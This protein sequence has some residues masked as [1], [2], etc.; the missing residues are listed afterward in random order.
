MAKAKIGTDEFHDRRKRVTDLV[1][2]G[3]S[4]LER[5][6]ENSTRYKAQLNS[7]TDEEFDDWASKFEPDEFKH[8]IQ[9]FTEPFNEPKME[10]I[11]EC[12][13]FLQIPLEE[14][15]YFRDHGDVPIRTKM[16]VPVGYIHIKRMRVK[17]LV[18]MILRD[19]KSRITRRV[20]AL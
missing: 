10:N 2:G 17:C 20:F 19:L 8:C 7:M 12:A 18:E 1:L 15:I 16:K 9:I 11:E 5:G 4:R 14:Y 6:N 3:V 13:K